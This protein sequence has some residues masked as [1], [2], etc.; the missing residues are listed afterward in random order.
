MNLDLDAGNCKQVNGA[1]ERA[2]YVEREREGQ[3]ESLDVFLK[4]F[5]FCGSC[6]AAT[7]TNSESV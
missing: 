5:Q 7:V 1:Q 6:S 2:R 4:N 3:R